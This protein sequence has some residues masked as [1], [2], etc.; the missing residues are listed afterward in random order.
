MLTKLSFLSLFL[1]DLYFTI[2]GLIYLKSAGEAIYGLLFLI[3]IWYI[4]WSIHKINTYRK[5]GKKGS[6][7]SFYFSYFS[8]AIKTFGKE[9]QLGPTKYFRNANAL[10]SACVGIGVILF[11]IYNNLT[12][13]HLTYELILRYVF[14]FFYVVILPLGV[15]FIQ[16][17]AQ[18]SKSA[19][20][21]EKISA[22]FPLKFTQLFIYI[23]TFLSPVAWLA[24]AYLSFIIVKS[25]PANKLLS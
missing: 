18:D 23:F 15:Y 20:L 8:L 10:L 21:T 17:F 14:V 5:E 19:G 6:F 2:S 3:F 22:F 25:T 4:V 13:I 12:I 9:R 24:I 7:M 16:S 11:L 1:F